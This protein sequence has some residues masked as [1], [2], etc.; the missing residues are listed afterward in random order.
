MTI[1]SSDTFLQ[2]LILFLRKEKK[3]KMMS[4][5]TSSWTSHLM[6]SEFMVNLSKM[7]K[8]CSPYSHSSGKMR[9]NVLIFNDTKTQATSYKK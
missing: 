8:I 4:K 1:Q 3:D 2:S 9:V 5:F 6:L 7:S